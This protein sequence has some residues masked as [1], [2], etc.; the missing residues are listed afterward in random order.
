MTN[1]GKS[2]PCL[3]YHAH[4]DHLVCHFDGGLFGVVLLHA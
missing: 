1:K 4:A 3:G 2:L